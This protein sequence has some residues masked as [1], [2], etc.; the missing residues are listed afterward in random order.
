MKSRGGRTHQGGV[1]SHYRPWQHLSIHK[2]APKQRVKRQLALSCLHRILNV[3]PPGPP[4]P[5]WPQTSASLW[6]TKKGLC[7]RRATSLAAS[8]GTA[9]WWRRSTWMW[10]T[11]PKQTAP[12]Q[13]HLPEY[14]GELGCLQNFEKGLDLEQWVKV[15]RTN[16]EEGCWS[17]PAISVRLIYHYWVYTKSMSRAD[18]GLTLA[19]VTSAKC[20]ALTCCWDSDR[21]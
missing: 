4:P 11:L 3:A 1:S 2:S 16:R 5:P 21:T 6:G 15:R 9:G 13:P 12:S 19:A 17:G 7:N 14:K 8:P 10:H 18:R 20:Q